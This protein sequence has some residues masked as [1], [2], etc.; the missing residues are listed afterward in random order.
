MTGSRLCLGSRNRSRKNNSALTCKTNQSTI[1]TTI[2]SNVMW[3][4]DH[5][6]GRQSINGPSNRKIELK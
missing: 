4:K 2:G 5:F 1:D 3:L 6:T